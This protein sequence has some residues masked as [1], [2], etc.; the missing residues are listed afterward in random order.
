MGDTKIK[1]ATEEGNSVNDLKRWARMLQEVA[2]EM[3]AQAPRASD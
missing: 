2:Q 1:P 3:E